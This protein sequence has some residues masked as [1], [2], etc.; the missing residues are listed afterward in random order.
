MIFSNEVCEWFKQNKFFGNYLEIGVYDGEGI[1]QLA[2]HYPDKIIYAVDP[3]IEDGC[4]SHHSGVERFEKLIP[5]R[6]STINNIRGIKNI[7]LY[8]VTSDKFYRRITNPLSYNIGA[9][10]IDGSHHYKDVANDFELAMF[11][12]GNK[13]GII[14]VDDLQVE[15]VFNAYTEFCNMF[16][17]R[18]DEMFSIKENC[19]VIKINEA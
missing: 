15:D 2:L 19:M 10:F 3:F 1:K 8:E 4:T 7:E 9:V 12:I 6:Q 18:I 14:S 13:S 11:L 5:Q 17:S 16:N